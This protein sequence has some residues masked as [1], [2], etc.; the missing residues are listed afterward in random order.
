MGRG[1]S[2]SSP[3]RGDGR[4]EEPDPLGKGGICGIGTGTGAGS[5]GGA[6]RGCPGRSPSQPFPPFPT[7]CRSVRRSPTLPATP[8]SRCWPKWPR[9]CPAARPPSE[10][11]SSA[12]WWEQLPPL[13]FFTRFSGKV[14]GGAFSSASWCFPGGSGRS[15]RLPLLPAGLRTGA[16]PSPPFPN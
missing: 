7:P 10:S 14:L 15:R 11:I 5:A 9:G 8:C 13:C 3:A 12:A 4:G 2:F 16:S 1:T 6:A